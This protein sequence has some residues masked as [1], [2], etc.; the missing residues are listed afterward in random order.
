MKFDK[1]NSRNRSE[2]G[3]LF[4]EDCGSKVREK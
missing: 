4:S 1:K 2:T 3:V